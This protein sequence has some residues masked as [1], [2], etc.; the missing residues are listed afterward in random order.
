MHHRLFGEKPFQEKRIDRLLLKL[1]KLADEF[2]A[3]QQ[4][5]NNPEVESYLSAYLAGPKQFAQTF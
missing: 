4:L 1:H 2:I 5:R 3:H